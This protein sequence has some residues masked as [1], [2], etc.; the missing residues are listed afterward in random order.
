[1]QNLQIADG[2]L[3]ANE[4]MINLD[5]LGTLM[6]DWVGGHVDSTDIITIYQCSAT[7]RGMKLLKK[8]AQPRCLCNTIS[9]CTVLC[10]GTGSGHGVLTLRGPGDEIVTKEHS[11]ARGG[12][13]R[14][15]TACPVSISVDL[16]ISRRRRS[17]QKTKVEGP[18]ESR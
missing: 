18:F 12:I 1:M 9:N 6:L 8:L 10:F 5:M 14:I 4:V 15:R 13:A 2:Y 7:E 17:Q 11:I 3:F 16:E